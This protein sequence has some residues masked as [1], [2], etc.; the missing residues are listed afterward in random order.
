MWLRIA[1]DDRRYKCG[2]KPK[3]DEYVAQM[4][5]EGKIKLSTDQEDFLTELAQEGK[6]M[7]KQELC[8][9][10]YKKYHAVYERIQKIPNKKVKAGMMKKYW[11][12]IV[13]F[14]NKHKCGW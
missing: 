4:K 12:I 6:K 9:D 3:M 10:Q 7:T 5:K 11:K 13:A 2:L 14:D 1:N 8:K